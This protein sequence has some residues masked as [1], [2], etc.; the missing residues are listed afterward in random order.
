MELASACVSGGALA[1]L[2][3]SLALSSEFA[4][5][6]ILGN[7]T[8]STRHTLHDNDEATSAD[9]LSAHITAFSTFATA[10][11]YYDAAGKVDEAQ[12]KEIVATLDQPVVGC[13]IWRQHSALQPSMREQVLVPAVLHLLQS[14]QQTS[15][16]TAD[17]PVPLHPM[18]FANMSGSSLHGGATAGYQYLFYQNLPGQQALRP[19]KLRISNVHSSRGYLPAQPLS[20]LPRVSCPLSLPHEDSLPV[21]AATAAVA[22]L[23]RTF[24]S[25][26]SHSGVVPATARRISDFAG[27]VAAQSE[28]DGAEVGTTD[29]NLNSVTSA[30]VSGL[31]Q[32]TWRA[33]ELYW[34]LVGEVEAVHPGVSV[35]QADVASRKAVIA[36]LHDALVE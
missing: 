9:V 17:T 35:A 29:Q 16:Q 5:G 10:F 30:A 24:S 25:M 14:I 12:L 27:S 7:V 33:E 18:L 36:G 2:T 20:Y 19:L 23:T 15:H 34:H 8:S 1:A 3:A 21:S 32:Q 11:S 22:Q 6:F 31:Q 13:Y 28:D 4:D 26:S